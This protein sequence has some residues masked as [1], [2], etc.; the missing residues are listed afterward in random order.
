M[1]PM[2]LFLALGA[3]AVFIAGYVWLNHARLDNTEA[4]YLEQS[5]VTPIL[6][7]K[8]LSPHEE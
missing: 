4:T 1:K 3:A 7:P 2:Y 5:A 6:T 8:S